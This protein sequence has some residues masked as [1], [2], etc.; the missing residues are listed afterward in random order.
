M[1]L[2]DVIRALNADLG[3]KEDYFNE[4]YSSL[5][6]FEKA[7]VSADNYDGFSIEE[8]EDDNLEEETKDE[9]EDSEG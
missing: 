8:D 1:S 3:G 5:E 9:E 2:L 6:T 7:F 4:Y